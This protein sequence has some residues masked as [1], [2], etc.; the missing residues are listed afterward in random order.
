MNALPFVFIGNQLVQT[1]ASLFLQ[2]IKATRSALHMGLNVGS[3]VGTT[4]ILS[5]LP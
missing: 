5:L 4:V 1:D 2:H 3:S